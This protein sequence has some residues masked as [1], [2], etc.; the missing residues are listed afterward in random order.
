M[1][2]VALPAQQQQFR[3][4][5]DIFNTDL[6]H[7][8][9]AHYSVSFEN[10]RVRVLRFR[11][12]PH[13]KSMIVDVPAH[14]VVYVTEAHVRIL[15]AHGKPLERETKAGHSEWLERDAR[16]FENLSEKA[17]EWILIETKDKERPR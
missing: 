15:H 13:E 8:D 17:T 3:F 11:L 12:E 9:A 6:T 2:A 4:P 5:P 14:V 10:D 7:L 1:A 16:G